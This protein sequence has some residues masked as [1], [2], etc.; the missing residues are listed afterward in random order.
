[1]ES[2]DL[3]AAWPG[4]GNVGLVAVDVL[5]GIVQARQ[6]AEIE[7][8]DFFYPR[9]VSV[10]SGELKDLE[11]PTSRFYFQK[12]GTKELM[13]FIGEEQP[14]EAGGDER[15]VD[16]VLG[17]ARRFR[18]RRIY[19]AAAAVAPIHHSFR[20]RVWAVPNRE[21][22]LGELKGYSN[23]MLMSDVE[24]RRGQGNIS[25]L[26]GLLLGFARRQGIDGV[27]LLGEIPVYVAQFPTS[28]PKASKSVLEVLAGSLGL[29]L[30]LSRLDELIHEVESGIEKLCQQ[31]PPE[32]QQRIDQLRQVGYDEETKSGLITDDDKK[33]IMQEID[34]FF[35]KGG[36]EH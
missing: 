36:K 20:P 2:P 27:C 32:V 26:N 19:T 28:Y 5:R 35:G 22:L 11:F 30:D 16:L 14:G 9:R 18:C 23:T 4:I 25:G 6:F 34:S 3:I 24:G 13:F 1:M 15:L 21:G 10:T 12:I 7:P 17:I 8:W 29:N 33:R 31:F